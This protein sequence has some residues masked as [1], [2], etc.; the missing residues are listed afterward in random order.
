MIWQ[1]TVYP[2]A[3]TRVAVLQVSEVSNVPL[4]T[5]RTGAVGFDGLLGAVGLVEVVGLDGDVGFDG[6]VGVV[7]FV[8]VVGVVGLVGIDAAQPV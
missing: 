1:G 4:Y 7:G 8:V 2:V 5:V 3:L 6:D